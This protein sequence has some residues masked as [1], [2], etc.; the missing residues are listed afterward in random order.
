[1]NIVRAPITIGFEGSGG[2]PDESKRKMRHWQ[3]LPR[4]DDPGNGA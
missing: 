4:H 3:F 2:H 1:M